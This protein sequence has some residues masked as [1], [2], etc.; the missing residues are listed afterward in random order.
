M[1]QKRADLRNRSRVFRAMNFISRHIETPPP[2]ETVA[3]ESATSPY[4]LHRLFRQLTGETLLTFTRRLQMERARKH[5]LFGK[6]SVTVIAIKCGF[7]SSQNFA[8]AFRQFYGETP[9]AYRLRHHAPISKNGNA[10]QDAAPYTAL[11]V[12]LPA[13]SVR[14]VPARTVLY[15]RELAAYG[16]D[17]CA[18]AYAALCTQL[19]FKPDFASHQVVALYW[20]HPL[21]TDA[22]HCRTD[23]CIEVDERLVKAHPSCPS[24]QVPG[25]RYAVF[26]CEIHG[27]E[28]FA[29]AW[30]YAVDWLQERQHKLA[31]QP[32]YELYQAGT[33]LD[34]EY[35][36]VAIY[37]P[38]R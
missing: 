29:F 12:P 1:S 20:D 34:S 10:S 4:H 33:E 27:Q 25:G 13:V 31:D 14:E 7:S 3:Q 28:Q 22:V 26:D 32:A 23:L 35:Y 17:A 6:R 9:S 37:L 21:I 16:K 30:Q 11:T 18:R 38:I 5:L 15:A 2:L 24:Q 8:K 36:R 19:G